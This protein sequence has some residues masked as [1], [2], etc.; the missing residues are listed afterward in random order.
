MA[1]DGLDTPQTILRVDGLLG[2]AGGI[3]LIVAGHTTQDSQRLLC[4]TVPMRDQNTIHLV[5]T[6]ALATQRTN[7]IPLL[8]ESG[9]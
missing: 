9:Q 5:L 3:K 8:F 1:S 2:A 7:L 6:G 4:M